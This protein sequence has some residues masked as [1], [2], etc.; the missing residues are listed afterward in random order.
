MS[1]N[2]ERR[3][4]VLVIDAYAGVRRLGVGIE[5][6]CAGH[7]QVLNQVHII[8]QVPNQVLALPA[9]RLHPP[10][11]QRIGQF[12]RLERSRPARVEDLH[13]LQPASL[14]QRGELAPDRLDLG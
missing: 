5:Q 10:P 13:A 4:I 3:A 6:H 11:L 9:K 7:A 2:G 8:L 1:D 12:A 14:Y